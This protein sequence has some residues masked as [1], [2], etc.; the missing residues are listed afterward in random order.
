LGDCGNG[1]YGLIRPDPLPARLTR[2]PG[3]RILCFNIRTTVRILIVS[4]AAHA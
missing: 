2:R 3:G 1:E 4:L